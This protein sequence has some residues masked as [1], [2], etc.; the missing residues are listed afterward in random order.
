MKTEDNDIH[1]L[2]ARWEQTF[3]H[4]I[5]RDPA[6]RLPPTNEALLSKLKAISTPAASEPQQRNSQAASVVNW[7]VPLMAAASLAALVWIGISSKSTKET[8]VDWAVLDEIAPERL[9]YELDAAAIY[10]Y[11]EAYSDELE[12]M[13]ALELDEESLENWLNNDKDILLWL[14]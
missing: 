9:Q 1:S 11:A 12:G 10:D 13:V 2:K 5:T 3:G 7:W 8:E 6:D 4:A 14:E